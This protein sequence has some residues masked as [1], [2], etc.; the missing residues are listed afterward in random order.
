MSEFWKW[1][2]AAASALGVV[3]FVVGCFVFIIYYPITLLWLIAA[4][5]LVALFAL[6]EHIKGAFFD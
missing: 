5:F 1:V 6:T 2:A 4:V 3:S